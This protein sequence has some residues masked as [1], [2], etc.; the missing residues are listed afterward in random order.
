MKKLG[1]GMMRL[2]FLG[3]YN[4]VNV[5]KF[6]KLAD[7]FIRQGFT[8]FDTG[9]PYHGGNSE[10]AFREA[11][12]KRHP[13]T[14]YVITD[15]M[16]MFAVEKQEQLQQ[17]FDEQLNRCGVEYFDYYLLHCLDRKSYETTQKTN[18]FGFIKQKKQEGKIKC[19]G[20][21]Y[22]DN[23]ELLDRI[24]TEH[25]EVELVQLQMN[26]MDFDDISIESGKC[27]DLAVKHGKKV[28]IMEPLKG[29]AL[30]NVPDEANALFKGYN[31]NAS[32]A[33]WGLRYAASFEKVI[34]VLSGMNS[35]EQLSDNINTMSNFLPLNAEEKTV[36]SKAVEVIKKGIAIACTEC[37]YCVG[38]C[39]QNIAIPEYFTI[40]NNLKRFES[41]QMPVAQAYYGNLIQ[42]FGKASQC[43][44][45]GTCE[46]HCPQHLH[47]REHLKE[48][49]TAL[50]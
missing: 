6:K 1:F 20:F 16:P 37:R 28:I 34:M 48:I 42:N 11:V 46:E 47:I 43:T 41:T 30:A 50:E 32:I 12:A 4:N 49:A 19:I 3:E 10:T 7:D 21:S 17:F 25:P 14:S 24:L 33:S 31:P 38:K 29:G 26:Y 45:C 5:E 9:Y 35:E 40:Y 23:A 39:P 13:R 44:Q 36:I 22:H 27:Y 15:K 2:P 18:A 8:Y